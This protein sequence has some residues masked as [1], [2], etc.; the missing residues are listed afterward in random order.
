VTTAGL[1]YE[2]EPRETIVPLKSIESGHSDTDFQQR[3]A[4][5]QMVAGRSKRA[6]PRDPDVRAPIKTRSVIGSLLQALIANGSL[7]LQKLGLAV[8]HDA[9]VA[10]ESN[11]RFILTSA[12]R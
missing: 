3:S 8:D 5:L 4:I 7:M 12:G 1:A 10:I 2:M 11:Q 9:R 6:R